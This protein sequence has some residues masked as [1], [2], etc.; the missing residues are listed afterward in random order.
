VA[1]P[2]Q[3]RAIE[4][5]LAR[6]GFRHVRLEFV[7]GGHALEP[8]PLADALRWFDERRRDLPVPAGP[9]ASGVVQ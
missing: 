8:T 9:V 1:T 6:D 7:P 3:H 5:E 2:A 4:S